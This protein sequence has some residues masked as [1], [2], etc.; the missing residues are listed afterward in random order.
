MCYNF[1]TCFDIYN[2]LKKSLMILNLTRIIGHFWLFLV[3]IVFGMSYHGEFLQKYFFRKVQIILN[4]FHIYH[5]S[6]KWL[7]PELQAIEVAHKTL[8]FGLNQLRKLTNLVLKARA[9]WDSK[10]LI[11]ELIK[12]AGIATPNHLNWI[13]SYLRPDWWS[14]CISIF[15]V[16]SR[17]KSN[18]EW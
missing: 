8:I 1:P 16:Y 4:I 5:F 2:I 11:R 13:D 3:S 18:L 12:V 10:Y 6:W 17:L 7:L 9:I 15:I 14:N